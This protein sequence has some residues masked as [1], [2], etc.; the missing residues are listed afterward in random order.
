MIS[1]A[2]PV[3]AAT[4]KAWTIPPELL[5]SANAMRSEASTVVVSFKRISSLP[6]LDISLD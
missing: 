6:R 3:T 1:A 4:S 5:R 2:V